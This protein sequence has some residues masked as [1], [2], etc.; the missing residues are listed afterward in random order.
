MSEEAQDEN[1]GSMAKVRRAIKIVVLMLNNF[2]A[3][4]VR[5]G[6]IGPKTALE[7]AIKEQELPYAAPRLRRFWS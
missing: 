3:G 6:K 1:P 2:R 5:N 7:V 4:L